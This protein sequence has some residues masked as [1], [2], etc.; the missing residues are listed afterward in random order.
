M[1]V[2]DILYY[3]VMYCVS[4]AAQVCQF[5]RKKILFFTA[6]T[7]INQYLF[8]RKLS[9]FLFMVSTVPFIVFGVLDAGFW[10]PFFLF[11]FTNTSPAPSS[12]FH[13][14]DVIINCCLHSGK[15]KIPSMNYHNVTPT[16]C[17]SGGHF[18]L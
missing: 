1:L 12:S 9:S 16:T 8:N 4:C 17:Y 18:G 5:P 14:Y 10:S 3:V 13:P 7:F 11:S 6:L 15:S 2:T